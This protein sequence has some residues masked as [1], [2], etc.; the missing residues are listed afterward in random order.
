MKCSWAERE[1]KCSKF[2]HFDCGE[3][4]KLISFEVGNNRNTRWLVLWHWR[5]KIRTIKT[6]VFLGNNDIDKGRLFSKMTKLF[7]WILWFSL[8]WTFEQYFINDAYIRI[9]WEINFSC[10][11]DLE[12]TLYYAGHFGSL[13][14]ECP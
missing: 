10:I 3:I 9:I 8:L 7:D 14:F 1:D 11:E 5:Y 2:I 13:K 12:S 4:L 6:C